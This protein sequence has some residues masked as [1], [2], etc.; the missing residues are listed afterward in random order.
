MTGKELPLRTTGTLTAQPAKVVKERD[1][2]QE[3]TELASRGDAK[4]VN[5]L[6]EALTDPRWRVRRAA[7]DALAQSPAREQT[8]LAVLE[9]MRRGH[10]ELGLLNG[11]L[12]VL[13]QT[14][15]D[16][17]PALSAF[18]IESD[19]DLRNYAALALGER[20]D[21]AAVPVLLRALDDAD[22]NVRCQATEALGKLRSAAATDALIAIAET[23]EF[24]SAWAAL[25]A[26]GAIGDAR[27]A[28]RLFPLL[29]DD[30][31]AEAAVRAVGQLGD[32]EAI[33]P[34]IA[35]LDRNLVPATAVARALALVHERYRE[36]Y[37]QGAYI[38]E[39]VRRLLG[40]AALQK[41]LAEVDK[42]HA[43]EAPFLARALGWLDGEGVI[44]ALIR[45]LA[46]PEA[47][48]EAGEA[49]VRKGSAAS[50]AVAELLQS[51][52]AGQLRSAIE[53]LGRIGDPSH[54]PALIS[55]LEH[56][57][58]IAAVT[59]G[60]LTMIGDLRA[61]P[62][63]CKLLGH[64]RAIV[65]Q[66][67]V[68]AINSVAHPDRARNLRVWLQDPEPL[69]RESALK[70]ACYLGF[71]ECIEPIFACCSDENEQVRKV[72]VENIALLDD[73]RVPAIIAG[74][75]KKGTA[76]VRAAAARAMTGEAFFQIKHLLVEALTDTDVWV[77]YFAAKSLGTD[78]APE[79]AIV[80]PLVWVAQNDIAMQV[81]IAAVEALGRM[82]HATV[83]PVLKSLANAKETDLAQ[84]ALKALGTTRQGTA[85]Q[86][87]VA[88][89]DTDEP[90][91]RRA[92]LQALGES[93]QA[94]AV[95]PLC[96][97]LRDEDRELAVVAIDALGRLDCPEAVAALTDLTRWP[98]WRE[99]CIAALVH[100]AHARVSWIGKGLE[101]PD[102]DVR[103][104]IIEV[105]ARRREPAAT[106]M[107]R[108]ALSDPEP[109]VRQAAI[110]ALAHAAPKVSN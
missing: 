84:A 46:R 14:R 93:G 92:A 70:I 102:L 24:A 4:S 104:A 77:R 73:E 16:V 35:L 56:D 82:R 61:Y 48:S 45:L 100:A 20:G 90:E 99:T 18:L 79:E 59:A 58:E 80:R 29:Q 85:L 97:A 69:V 91:Q 60:A 3:I 52:D 53:L 21:P 26:L 65:R 11:A 75:L 19:P 107:L 74:V 44:K 30:L 23:R 42:S 36:C 55:F 25:D 68:A 110:A 5:Q 89:L 15:L 39:L 50:R 81:R 34:L 98:R 72:A 7:A 10:R 94:S 13:G 105:L 54:V 66:A 47:R 76:P 78:A 43:D 22:A 12:R 28:P 87:L 27:A 108:S 88:A 51:Q 103:R 31:F 95:E 41:L 109:A 62:A 57:D 32:E 49:L 6:T 106:G 71:S 9:A 37:S 96:R 8:L 67:V 33:A 83:L 1:C 64:P 40:P 101:N 63:L 86:V 38:A 2:L 17:V